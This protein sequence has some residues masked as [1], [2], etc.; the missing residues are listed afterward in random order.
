MAK[1][2]IDS[3]LVDRPIASATPSLTDLA[4]T[5]LTEFGLE[6]PSTMTGKTFLIR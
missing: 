1:V 2:K 3:K 4:P 6:V 5:I